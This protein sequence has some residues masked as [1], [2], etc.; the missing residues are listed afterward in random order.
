MTAKV[1]TLAT[2]TVES[3]R[4]VQPKTIFEFAGRP[5]TNQDPFRTSSRPG[6]DPLRDRYIHL[7]GD[8]SE[9]D[10][11]LDEFFR[12]YALSLARSNSRPDDRPGEQPGDER[13][14]RSVPAP[15]PSRAPPGTTSTARALSAAVAGSRA[16]QHSVGADA[17]PVAN[18]LLSLLRVAE[19]SATSLS[20][21]TGT[22]ACHRNEEKRRD[23]RLAPDVHDAEL[24]FFDPGPAV[25]KRR[26]Q[27]MGHARGTVKG[28]GLACKLL[29]ACDPFFVTGAQAKRA[30]QSAMALKYELQ[31]MFPHLNDNI[32]CASFN[33]HQGTLVQS[34]DITAEGITALQSGC[35]GYGF[36]R[37]AYALYSQFGTAV[38]VWPG[39]V[40]GPVR[41]VTRE[42]SW[43]GRS[44]GSMTASTPSVASS[45][46]STQ[47]AHSRDEH[48]HVPV[49]VPDVHGTGVRLE[50][51]FSIQ[52]TPDETSEMFQ[53]GHIRRL[54][55]AAILDVLHDDVPRR[56]ARLL[57][58][59]APKDVFKLIVLSVVTREGCVRRG[60][61]RRCCRSG[62]AGR[63]SGLP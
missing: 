58:H 20:V 1:V 2:K 28:W 19:E 16:Q 37:L 29:T 26:Q 30:Y 60:T 44:P 51:E 8:V 32:S 15:R 42:R 39:A 35:V 10:T 41:R 25:E 57:I 13:L 24:I 48:G 46:R 12:R 43:T 5:T 17:G 50:E 49:V 54:V 56:A 3:F 7:S 34:Y 36:E 31:V 33:H 23:A 18:G 21:F 47:D 4:R 59:Q 63:P 52:F 62:S 38:E 6:K 11:G 9:G 53:V 61:R 14:P 40:H 55:T 27:S 22:A 45:A